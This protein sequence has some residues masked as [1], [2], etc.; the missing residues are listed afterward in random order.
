M[1]DKNKTSL[2]FKILLENNNNNN[3]NNENI[4]DPE[5]IS[6]VINHFILNTDN[7]SELKTN[8]HAAVARSQ[9]YNRQHIV[10]ALNNIQI[11]FKPQY[12]PGQPVNINTNSFKSA[13]MESMAKIDKVA[14]PKSM[15]QIDSRTIDFV[16]MIFHAFIQDKNI[17]DNIKSL[18]LLMQI[19]ILKIA[20]TD[21]KFFNNDNHP[22]R[23]VLNSIARIGI[24]IEEKENTLYQTMS[25]IIDQLLHSYNNNIVAFM[26]AKTS[27][28]RLYE[29]QKN[30]HS[31]TERHTQNLIAIEYTQQLVLNELQHYTSCL[32]IPKALQP[33]ILTHWSTLMFHRFISYGKE[34]IEWREAVGIL[35]LLAK[36]FSP[37]D[38]KDDWVALRSIYKGLVNSVRSCLSSTRQNKEKI[39]IATSNLNNYY[40]S[41]LSDSKFFSSQHDDLNKDDNEFVL[42][43]NLYKVY[44]SDLEP[45]PVDIQFEAS[46]NALHNKP[47]LIQINS[48]FEVF[49]DYTHP[50]RRLKL[51]SIM[52]QQS[53]LIF[54][55]Y[56][57][58]RVI[59]KDLKTFITELQNDQSR[60]INDHSIFEYALS[61]VIISIAAK[62]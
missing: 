20:L 10:T 4:T 35:R 62:N 46:K 58:N 26:S 13:L 50:V 59:E 7:K 37:I 23:Y 21:A 19:P 25:Y 33:L 5:Y 30:K 12:V 3:N 48:W 28:D 51:S 52:Q 1:I 15:N 32:K 2:Q 55:D 57:G 31:E 41:K 54:V 42:F 17:S 44:T 11:T 6:R 61:I 60:L 24:G 43:D 9:Q 27:L 8:A 47:D 22:A 49:T 38:K 36:S 18:L 56:M 16:E 40:F 34:S 45:S 53:K 29:I 39:F 14:I